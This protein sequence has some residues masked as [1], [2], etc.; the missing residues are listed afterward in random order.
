MKHAVL[1][2][3]CAFALSACGLFKSEPKRLTTPNSGKNTA[4]TTI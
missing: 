2:L 1:M 3:V 4:T